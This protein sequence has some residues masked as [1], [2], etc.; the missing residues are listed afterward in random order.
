MYISN[1]Q[2]TYGFGLAGFERSI[3]CLENEN[4]TDEIVVALFHFSPCKQIVHIVELT[5]ESVGTKLARLGVNT[6]LGVNRSGKCP[7]AET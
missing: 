5:L 2:D 7:P 3:E 1:G 4:G 6:A